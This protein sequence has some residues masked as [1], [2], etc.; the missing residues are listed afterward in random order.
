SPS[1][2]EQLHQARRRMIYEELFLYQIQLLFAKKQNDAQLVGRAH[3]FDRPLFDQFMQE[4]ALT[5]TD[6]QQRVITEI[7]HDLTSTSP[8]NRLLQGDVGSGKTLVIAAILY[9]NF[10]AGDQGAV[11]VPTEILAEQHLKTLNG[12][13]AKYN[14]V[15]R[16][17][18]GSMPKAIKTES[19]AQIASGEIDVIVGT[20]ALIQ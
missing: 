19:L 13:L 14:V 3:M 2:S 8:M 20:H 17:L 7:L 16:L 18:T 6:A 11:M 15:I 4:L 10:L 5:P 9:A 1:S 12:F